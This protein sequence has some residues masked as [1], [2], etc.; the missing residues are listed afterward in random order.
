MDFHQLAQPPPPQT[1]LDKVQGVEG[2]EHRKNLVDL[3]VEEKG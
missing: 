3:V 2:V 1:R